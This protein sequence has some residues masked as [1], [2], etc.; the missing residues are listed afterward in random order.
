MKKIRDNAGNKILKIINDILAKYSNENKISLIMEK[1][2]IV[3]GKSE[4]DI[5]N[6]ILSLLNAK[7]KKVEIS[8]EW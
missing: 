5:T 1:K 7:I 4:L 8:N 6:D 3:I 2:N